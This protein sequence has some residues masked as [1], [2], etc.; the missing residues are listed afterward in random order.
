MTSVAAER[1]ARLIIEL[2]PYL[3]EIVFVGGWVHT[4]YLAE[5]HAA[6]GIGTEDIDIALPARLEA[7]ARP[8]VLELAAR[9]GF[10]RDPI[11]DMAGAST[12]MVY[13]NDEGQTVPIDFLTEGEPRQA[14]E[15]A[16]QPGLLAQGYRGQRVLLENTRWL[17]V[18]ARL[19]PMLS[20][21]IQ[22]RVPTLGAYLL[23]K[24]VSAGTRTH[25]Q[26]RAKDLVYILEI[27]SH[28]RLG[29]VAISELQ[30]LKR[31]YQPEA[32]AFRASLSEA[33]D[34]YRTLDDIA[35]QIMMARGRIADAGEL[36]ARQRAWLRRLLA[37]AT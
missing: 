8:M 12:W 28:P 7:G 35:E 21:S 22:V 19:H 6:A 20:T 11:S 30:E 34:S 23:Q 13:V 36:R 10:E 14:V 37:N 32:E 31:E 4:L 33:I 25:A 17:R 16:G 18:G 26:K 3:E 27:A 15:I 2:E 9:A 1:F 5:E 29:A 24:G